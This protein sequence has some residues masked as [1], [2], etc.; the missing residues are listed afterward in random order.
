[1]WKVITPSIA[2]IGSVF[3]W[4]LNKSQERKHEEYLRKEKRYETLIKKLSGFYVGSES[5]QQK[6]DFIKEGNLCWLYCPDE[7]IQ[8]IYNFLSKVKVGE[9]NTDAEKEIA[10][11]DLM[12]AIRKDLISR[13]IVKQTNLKAKDFQNL[14]A[15]DPSN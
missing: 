3:L 11:G 4:L 15:T 1:M 14:S 8:K 5:K 10:V 2:V 9:V 7:V 6:D 12:L 13:K